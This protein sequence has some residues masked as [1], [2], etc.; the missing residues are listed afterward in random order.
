MTEVLDK[1][2][3][4][5]KIAKMLDGMFESS[6]ARSLGVHDQVEAQVAAA[7]AWNQ[8]YKLDQELS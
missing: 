5:V 1:I 6:Q 7:A 2:K 4:Q 8:V 3:H